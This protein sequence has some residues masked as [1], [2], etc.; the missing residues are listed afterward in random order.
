M[1]PR[2]LWVSI[3]GEDDWPTW[4]RGSDFGLDRLAHATEI[5]LG[6]D[7]HVLRLCGRGDILSFH[8]EYGCRPAFADEIG[9]DHLYR[10][11]AVR[12]GV[13]AERYQGIIIAPYVWSLRLDWDVRWYYSWDC[14]SGCIW[15]ARAVAELRSLPPGATVAETD[16]ATAER[17]EAAP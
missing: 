6:A 8:R 15:D 11:L 7:A 5:M 1:K 10:G 16:R 14:A 12:W 3:E 17:Q 2:G 13:V 4:C 9:K